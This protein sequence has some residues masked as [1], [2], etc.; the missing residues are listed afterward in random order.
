MVRGFIIVLLTLL[1]VGCA[2]VRWR[3]AQS[4]AANARVPAS[5]RSAV[6]P[7]TP[8]SGVVTDPAPQPASQPHDQTVKAM[9]QFDPRPRVPPAPTEPPDSTLSSGVV[10]VAALVAEDET[11]T[12][13][14][15]NQPV[16]HPLRFEEVVQSVYRSY[17]ALRAALFSRNIALGEQIAAS[18]A[19]DLKIKADSKN[20][21]TGFY[22]TY[23]QNIGLVQPT[24]WGGEV[25]GGYRIGRGDFEPWYLERQTNDGG[26]FRAGF[27][28]PLARNHEIDERRAALWRAGYERLLVE[29][30]IQAQLISFVQDAGYAYWGWVA[31]GEQYRLTERVLSYATD[32]TDRIRDQVDEGL[33]DPPELTDNLRLVAERR[34]MLAEAARVLQQ[35]AV[36]LS[37]YWRDVNGNPVIPDASW[38]PGFPEPEAV[39]RGRLAV[40]VQHAVMNRPETRVLDFIRR[41]LDI[42][43]AAAEN[44]LL[45]ELDAVVYGSQDVGEPTSPKRDKSQFELEAALL[46]E[47]PLQRRKARGKMTAIQGKVAQLSQKRRLTRDQIVADVEYAYA[48]LVAAYEQVIQTREAVRLADDLAERER[49]NQ[50]EGLSDLLKVTLREQY[51]AEAGMKEI[52]ALLKYFQARS[53][54][55]AAL[56]Q[57]HPAGPPA[58]PP[59]APP[60]LP[61][62]NG[63]QLENDLPE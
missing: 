6:A 47:M 36:K 10:L 31:A 56:A 37:L 45:P 34:A 49:I 1:A 21:P 24:Y 18:G 63:P 28:V 30:E 61:E 16:L 13:E 19:F 17:P 9:V 62:P 60:A 11:E 50:E 8:V 48:A 27:E 40:D 58:P 59:P 33:I 29:P 25:F 20:G 41:Q 15:P 44:E 12:Q 53:D 38:L 2:G 5:Q 4:G 14:Q 22:Q 26:E 42:D 54:Y 32:R 46:F 3:Q 55:R 35:S 43:Y 52:S 57:D 51:A 7:P 39:D 23:R